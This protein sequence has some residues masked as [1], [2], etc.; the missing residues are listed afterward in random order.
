MAL[1]CTNLAQLNLKGVHY[2]LGSGER[3]N[4]LMEIL[5]KFTN[6]V[7]LSL[8]NCVLGLAGENKCSKRK[9]G[10]DLFKRNRRV[11]HGKKPSS[12]QSSDKS[13]ASSTVGTAV[14]NLQAPCKELSKVGT[15]D[16]LVQA[17]SKIT[18]L[19]LIRSSSQG[20]NFVKTYYWL[21]SR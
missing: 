19:E 5:S 18:E 7:S 6:L 12:C 2:G 13:A 16:H 20:I 17:C 9:F 11:C 4:I 21:R 3:I 15:F 1:C 8:C 10:E 14:D